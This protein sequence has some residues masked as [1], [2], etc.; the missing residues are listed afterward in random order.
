MEYEIHKKISKLV[1]RR[2]DL[3]KKLDLL[4]GQILDL[5][6]QLGDGRSLQYDG[7]GV[8]VIKNVNYYKIGF[9]SNLNDRLNTLQTSTPFTLRVVVFI[10]CSINKAAQLESKLHQLFSDKNKRGEWFNL[11]HI[12]IKR[13]VLIGHKFTDEYPLQ[14]LFDPIEITKAAKK[15]IAN[16]NPDEAAVLD[17]I[18]E[19][20]GPRKESAL[21]E[22]IL[23]C[24][25]E[26]G[27]DRGTVSQILD[28]MKRNGTIYEPRPGHVKIL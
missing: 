5:E 7:S 8:Y 18:T 15:G 10:P 2:S 17:I 3:I 6:L 9:A 19:I 27:L 28:Q 4:N 22:T 14:N 11:S 24:A 20:Q 16:E 12:D 1:A 21:V 13:I 23:D 26:V 25:D